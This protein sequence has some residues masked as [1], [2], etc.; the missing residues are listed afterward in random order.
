M[1]IMTR[2]TP[3]LLA[4]VALLG[5][6]TPDP[7]NT[8]SPTVSSPAPTTSS[9]TPTPTPTP[10]P[11]P[12]STLSPEQEAAQAAV[13]EYFRALNAVRSDPDAEFQQVADVTTG[14][15]TSD[16]AQVVNDYR[17]KGAVQVGESRYTYKGIGPVVDVEGVRSVEVHVCSDSTDSDMVGA[18]GNSVLDPNRSR[19]VDSRLDVIEVGNSWRVSGGQSETVESC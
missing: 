11:S 14:T 9:A 1:T 15:F 8:P 10:S 18:D 2:L 12:S 19:F 5:A 13:V 16:L 17:S 3:A 4:A 7:S 6:C